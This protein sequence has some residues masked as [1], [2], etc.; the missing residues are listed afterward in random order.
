MTCIKALM[1]SKLSTNCTNNCVFKYI[2][3]SFQNTKRYL[4]ANDFKQF[5]SIKVINYLYYVL[6]IKYGLNSLSF[7]FINNTIS[8]IQTIVTKQ[9][10]L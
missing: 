9:S 10:T 5:N 6:N 3:N 2:K 4:H 7:I 8:N 1:H